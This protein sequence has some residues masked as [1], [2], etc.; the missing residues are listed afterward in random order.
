LLRRALPLVAV[1]L[2]AGALTAI[3]APRAAAP[4]PRVVPVGVEGEAAS[5][6]A[7]R[8][9]ITL[10]EATPVR[11][12][13]AARRAVSSARRLVVRLG[14]ATAVVAEDEDGYRERLAPEDLFAEL[15][16]ASEDLLVEA[17]G[18]LTITPATR[19]RAGRATLA[20]RRIVVLLPPLDEDDPYADDIEGLPGEEFS[21][22]E[23]VIDP[24][25]P[26][27]IPED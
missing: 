12:G 4:A 14:P 7:S 16:D 23:P 20:A 9:T 22:E 25:D 17:S 13:R 19:A 11:G 15:D 21:D 18:R 24:D 10:V 2:A 27:P 5:W 1:A 3:A 8:G 6:N 26:D